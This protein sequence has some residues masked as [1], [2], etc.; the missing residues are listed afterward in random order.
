MYQSNYD[1]SLAIFQEHSEMVKRLA[2]PSEA[3][4]AGQVGSD[5]PHLEHMAF[6]LLIEIGEVAEP[7][8][9]LANE[10]NI[11]TENHDG[12][13]ENV[14]EELGD[15]EFFMSGIRQPLGFDRLDLR[16]DEERFSFVGDLPDII[17][18]LLISASHLC[19]PF[20]K[21]AVY[22]KELTPAMHE[23]A[24]LAF[25]EV[26][27]ALRVIRSI[28]GFSLPQVLEANMKKLGQRYSS[29]TYSDAQAIARADKEP[30]Q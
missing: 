2:K 4:L 9:A 21:H 12:L 1:S 20:K 8:V 28:L 7:L 3:L 27:E 18:G 13:I 26:E 14:L 10:A 15:I 24:R 17:L 11:H 25:I 16:E 6:A 5:R 19:D 30:G 22:G 29:G 23:S